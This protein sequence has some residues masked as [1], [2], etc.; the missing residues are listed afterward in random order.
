ML[1]SNKPYSILY[2]DDE[3]QNLLSFQ[4]L[5]RRSYNVFTTS[6]A[7]EA[8]DILNSHDIQ[9]IFSD[10][11]MPDVSGVEFFETILPDFPHAVRILLT[12][13]ADIEAVI[14]AINKGQVY[15]YVAKPWDANELGICIEN[16]L[17]KYNRDLTLRTQN[18]ALEKANSELAQLVF[19][20]SNQLKPALENI[21]HAVNTLESG[22]MDA[23][24]AE[25]IGSIR[26]E[27]AR[28]HIFNKQIS[29]FYQNTHSDVV[30]EE[31]NLQ[32]LVT[33]IIEQLPRQKGGPVWEV[34]TD[35][36]VQGGFKS[37]IKRITMIVQSVLMNAIEHSDHAKSVNNIRVSVIQNAE[38]AVFKIEDE[39]VGMDNNTLE[40][41][42]SMELQND[43]Q[44][45]VGVGL[46]LTRNAVSK[47]L[48]KISGSSEPGKGTRITFE[49]PNRG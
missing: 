15:R 25:A 1:S 46:H 24:S 2:L 12:G 10:Q 37:D 48:G 35:I 31:V 28:L 41:L 8:V 26:S 16:A 49:L 11:K 5:F 34:T 13:Y 3:E 17:E 20:A 44:S 6:S 39:G 32:N 42:L 38:K 47:L 23:L 30:L 19:S 9:V 45:P 36:R 4:A 18:N 7:H 29:Q 21:L 14:D 33:E 43:V 22:Q 40:R 27:I